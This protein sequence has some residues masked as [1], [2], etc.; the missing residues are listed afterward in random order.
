MKPI[1]YASFAA[2]A[3]QPIVFVMLFL[4]PMVALGAE[5]SRKDFLS[6]PLF[7]ALIAVPFV[8]IVGIPSLIILRHFNRLSWRSLGAVGFI[9]AALPIAI[10]SWSDYPG[11]SSGGN[12]YGA[13]AD[14][15]INGRKTPFGWLQYAQGILE[16][17]LH[18]L[19]GALVFYLVWHRWS[20]PNNRFERSRGR[21]FGKPR[22]G[23]D[24]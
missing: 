4:L 9:A 10:Y 11:Y 5:I 14:F 16:F 20:G 6:L 7:S 3:I 23:V 13:P 22:K 2:I 15:V 12:W 18:G 17:G 19:I 24:D 8:V 21:V 1:L